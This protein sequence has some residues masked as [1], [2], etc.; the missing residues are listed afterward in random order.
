MSPGQAGASKGGP[1]PAKEREATWP[2]G[3]AGEGREGA[4]RKQ[5]LA[6]APSSPPGN[7]V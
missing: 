3:R 6:E 2:Q 4:R 7:S 5:R 1:E